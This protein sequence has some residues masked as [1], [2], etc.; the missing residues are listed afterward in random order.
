LRVKKELI[1]S[2]IKRSSTPLQSI[3]ALNTKTKK[4]N[5]SAK[6]YFYLVMR[7]RII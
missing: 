2:L 7:R 4:K 3:D 6:V 5:Y 1:P